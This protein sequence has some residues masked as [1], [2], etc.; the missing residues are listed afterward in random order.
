M[1]AA[2]PAPVHEEKAIQAKAVDKA[3][4]RIDSEAARRDLQQAMEHLNE[5]AQ[6]NNYNLNFSFDQ[7]SQQVVVKVRDSSSGEIIRQIPDDTVLHLAQHLEDLK[8]LLH[9]KKI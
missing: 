9:D 2:K 6:K 8:G 7:A 3:A 5:Q 4:Q 1:R